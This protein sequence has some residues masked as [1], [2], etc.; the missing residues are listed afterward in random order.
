[1]FETEIILFLAL[2]TASYYIRRDII[3]SSMMVVSISL[4]CGLFISMSLFIHSFQQAISEWIIKSTQD[5]VYIQAPYNTIPN[6][7]PLS[8]DD[9]AQ[10]TTHS[11][12]I[13]WQGISRDNITING[14]PIILRGL[15]YDQFNDQI[16][17]IVLDDSIQLDS[18]DKK[19]IFISEAASKKLG[20]GV[21]DSLS[22][23]TGSEF[24]TSTVNGI[25]V[26]YASE[27]GVITISN[28][29]MKTYY[30][31]Q[32]EYHGVSLTLDPDA[33]SLFVTEFDHLI[34]QTNKELQ[35]YVIKMFKQTFS[36]TWVLASISGL[37]ALF[38]LI[39]MV[40]VMTIDRRHEMIQLF[41]LGAQKHH[42]RQFVYAHTLWIGVISMIISLCV[43]A[44]LSFIILKLLTP[45]YFGW[46]IPY[47]IPYQPI[48]F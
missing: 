13:T 42:I 1:M 34:V 44:G 21:G 20:V 31:D 36:L 6:P 24:F 29:I 16:Q 8:A 28:E 7:V 33:L 23:P 22:I 45:G 48:S 43:G 37:I 19:A 9:V 27:Q 32:F 4:A 14:F 35:A 46:V 41:T 39:N 47:R 40:S 18:L 30:H 17:W 11:S 5:D 15:S 38:V 2:K 12:V 26:D 25:Y 3:L 10:I